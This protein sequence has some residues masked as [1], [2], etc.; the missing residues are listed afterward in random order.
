MMT[1]FRI[2]N[3]RAKGRNKVGVVRTNEWNLLLSSFYE[4]DPFI[5]GGIRG[6]WKIPQPK[7]PINL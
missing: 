3:W 5:L 4:R 2:L 1:I 6:I 7:P